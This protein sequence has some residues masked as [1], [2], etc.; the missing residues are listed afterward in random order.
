MPSSPRQKKMIV[1]KYT[2]GVPIP[3]GRRYTHNQRYC[4]IKIDRISLW[5]EVTTHRVSFT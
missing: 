3:E 2:I 4:D 5:P 1:R